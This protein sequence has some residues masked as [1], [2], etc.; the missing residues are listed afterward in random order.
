MLEQGDAALENDLSRRGV[1][2]YQPV[3]SNYAMCG[4]CDFENGSLTLLSEKIS[5]TEVVRRLR[6]ALS[7][8]SVR[9][10]RPA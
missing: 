1:D 2:A 10:E 5:S 8:H 7:S 9:I 3:F 6:P 4:I